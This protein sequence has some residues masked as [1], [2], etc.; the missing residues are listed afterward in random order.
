MGMTSEEEHWLYGALLASFALLMLLHVAGLV[1]GRWPEFTIGGALLLFGLALLF[2][3]FLHGE[4][5]PENYASEAAQHLALGI[6]LVA[7]STLELYRA[8]RRRE[9]RIWRLPVLLAL[10]VAGITFLIHAQHE[11]DVPM[12]LLVTQHRMIGATLLALAA[13]VLFAPV[14]PAR[15][16]GVAAPLLTLLLG[17]QLLVYSEG[18]SPFGVP[19]EDHV[20]AEGRHGA[21]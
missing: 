21:D 11:T 2:D 16:Q 7:G 15:R 4:A 17:V 8:A 1:L 18:R 14:G 5:R 19:D 10:V 6:V 3:P 20:A 13:A 12:L 9:A